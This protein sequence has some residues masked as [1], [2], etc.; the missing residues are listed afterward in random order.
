M[1]QLTANRT[2][3]KPTSSRA[4]DVRIIRNGMSGRKQ[5]R[6]A[7]PH[8]HLADLLGVVALDLRQI[9]GIR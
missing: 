5:L 8:H 2:R 9:D 7:R 1:K 3:P 6:Q 4:V